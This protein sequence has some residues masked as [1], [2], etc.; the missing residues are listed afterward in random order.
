MAE[1]LFQNLSEIRSPNVENSVL[2]PL[3]SAEALRDYDLSLTKALNEIKIPEGWSMVGDDRIGQH[4][5]P[6]EGESTVL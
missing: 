6:E 3:T 2:P 4:L 1:L 5:S